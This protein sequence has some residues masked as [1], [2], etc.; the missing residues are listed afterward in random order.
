M[1]RWY[2]FFYSCILSC[3]VKACPIGLAVT[4]VIISVLTFDTTVILYISSVTYKLRHHLTFYIS[5]VIWRK[6]HIYNCVYVQ[7]HGL[8]WTVVFRIF[9]QRQPHPLCSCSTCS[10]V[11]SKFCLYSEVCLKTEPTLVFRIERYS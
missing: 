1:Q 8:W 9:T 7:P 3:Y 10:D 11:S 4:L 6:T 2:I 5:V